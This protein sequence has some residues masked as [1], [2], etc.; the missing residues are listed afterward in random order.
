MKKNSPKA[1]W[2]LLALLTVPLSLSYE[3]ESGVSSPPD[4]PR[5]KLASTDYLL[6]D[7]SLPYQYIPLC[8]CGNSTDT[9]QNENRTASTNTQ[10]LFTDQ[11]DT[12]S[13]RFSQMIL[14]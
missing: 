13:I 3:D 4:A 7:F 1:L 14:R 9:R 2:R 10:R 8:T 11:T 12:E 6:T 5:I